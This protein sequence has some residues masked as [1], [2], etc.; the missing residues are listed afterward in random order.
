MKLVKRI[1]MGSTALLVAAAIWIPCVHFFFSKSVEDFRSAKGI[2]P[3]AQQ[4]AARHLQLW[5][6]P[7]LR[8][9]ELG[10]MRHSNAEWDF[11]GRT[12]LVWSLGEMGLRN[13]AA[14]R[15]YL[16]VMDQII[17]ETIRLEKEQGMYFFLMPYA[18]GRA[19]LMQPERSQFLDSEIAMMLAARRILEE[20]PEYKP[21]LTERVE[22]MQA[23]MER[24]PVLSAESYPDE[25]WMFDNV[26]A[27]AAMRMADFLDHSNHEAFI[28]RWLTQ[29]RE[30]LTDP[31]T[32]I[33]ISSYTVDGQALDGPEGS[34]IWMV[35]HFLRLVD[36]DFAKDQYHRARQQLGREAAGFA[37]SREWPVS[38][39]GAMDID[40]G[41][42][43]PVLE[44]SPGASGMAFIAASSFGDDDYL[45]E[46]AA[47]LDFS[48]FPSRKAGR[49]KYCASNQVGD[50]ALLYASVLGPM[51]EVV[52]GGS[53]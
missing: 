34:S 27:L 45:S 47:T 40:S 1:A 6:E 49:L 10:R 9:Q 23:R 31:K 11:M 3:K 25:C 18:R 32:G 4:L 28:R 21:L 43:L 50:A 13:P 53:R 16:P 5:T 38:W 36:G 17:T 12:F 39:K 15:E 51:W 7:V 22:A 42:V 48:A 29:A 46:L 19:Y 26:A 37:W 30:K 8:E 20:K 24:G 35:S 52:K 14:K 41:P 33:L 2:S 44:I